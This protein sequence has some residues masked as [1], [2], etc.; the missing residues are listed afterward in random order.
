MEKKGGRDGISEKPPESHARK[1]Q[2]HQ[3]APEQ[4]HESDRD[5]SLQDLLHRRYPNPLLKSG[6]PMVA[7]L[8][9]TRGLVSGLTGNGV[10]K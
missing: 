10:V 6:K 1:K 7:T 2:E 5:Y 3:T 4:L 9:M 8:A